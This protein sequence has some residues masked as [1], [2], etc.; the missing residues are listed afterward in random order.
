MNCCDDYGDCT[1][2]RDCPV[3]TGKVLPHQ[4][5]HVQPG[6]DDTPL[7]DGEPLSHAENVALAWTLITWLT[8]VLCFVAVVA[9]AT[10]Y[11]TERWSDVLWAYLAAL[12]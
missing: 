10:G 3:R 7:Y 9:F 8:C 5:T 6:P 11:I 1:Q 12:S 4:V 2:G